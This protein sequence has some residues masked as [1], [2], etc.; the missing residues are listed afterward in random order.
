MSAGMTFSSVGVAIPL[1][2]IPIVATLMVEQKRLNRL[3]RETAVIAT[4]NSPMHPVRSHGFNARVL[5][6]MELIHNDRMAA[7]SE[8]EQTLATLKCKLAGSA[9]MAGVIS[10]AIKVRRT[11]RVDDPRFFFFRSEQLWVSPE[12]LSVARWNQL[13]DIAI[14]QEI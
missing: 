2:D 9:V 14:A 10:N 7:I 4:S 6:E 5:E 11:D 13:V 3:K 1:E 12:D 8:T